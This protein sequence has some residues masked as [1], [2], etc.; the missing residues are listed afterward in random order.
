[1]VHT[2]SRCAHKHPTI[3][4][5][6]TGTPY[7][8]TKLGLTT[9]ESSKT[10]PCELV[11]YDLCSCTPSN[12]GG[13]RRRTWN[14]PGASLRTVALLLSPVAHWL[15]VRL[16]KARAHFGPVM[17]TMVTTY[18]VAVLRA[19]IRNRVGDRAVFLTRY[20]EVLRE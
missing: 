9:L 16:P 20:L 15:A 11:I 2:L 18:D 1:M 4:T 8:L 6:T 5:P 14:T 17:T 19:R 13:A 10:Q 7:I 12:G 3:N